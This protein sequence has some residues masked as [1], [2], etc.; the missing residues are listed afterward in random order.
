MWHSFRGLGKRVMLSRAAARADIHTPS[1]LP[2]QS[3]VLRL[4]QIFAGD[5]FTVEIARSEDPSLTASVHQR[6]LNLAAERKE[7]FGL[8]L[9]RYA[10][11][12]FLYRLSVSEYQDFLC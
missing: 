9:T 4:A 6:L 5:S 3:L 2:N 1:Y 7:D 11:E 10:L 12:G 8:L